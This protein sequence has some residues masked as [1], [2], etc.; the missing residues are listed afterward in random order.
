[1]A[2]PVTAQEAALAGAVNMPVVAPMD[3]HVA[4]QLAGALAENGTVPPV[5]IEGLSGAIANPEEV[6]EVMLS[7][8]Q[9]V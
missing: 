6:G 4:V 3:P 5:A 2:V 8:P 1:M 7:E 9:T